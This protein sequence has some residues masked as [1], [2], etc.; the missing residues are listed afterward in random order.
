MT[1][2]IFANNVVAGLSVAALFNDQYITV[3]NGAAF[4]SPASGL[5][6]FN[7]TL[8][9]QGGGQLEIC[10]C[11]ARSGN[12]LTV[13]RGSDS[14]QSAGWPVGTTVSMRTTAA[15]LRD[16][17]DANYPITGGNLQGRMFLALDPTVQNEAATKNYVDLRTA[18]AYAT[19]SEIDSFTPPVDKAVS[20]DGLRS[21]TAGQLSALATATKTGLIPA[22]N[23]L[24][25]LV[26]GGLEGSVFWGVFSGATGIISWNPSSGQAGNTLPLAAP[27]N[28]GSYL[29][30]SVG[31]STPPGGAPAGTY[32][33]GDWLISDGATQWYHLVTGTTGTINAINVV[34]NPPVAGQ[35]NVQSAL[36]AIQA[37][38]MNY[39]PVTGGTMTATAKVTFTVSATKTT[40]L[41]GLDPTLSA[42]DHFVIA[43]GVY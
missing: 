23:E 36:T 8:Q 35:T 11:T 22:I 9:A 27:S 38:S 39:L 40:R 26:S 13:E 18:N 14:T 10:R 32:Y 29:I 24:K 28:M 31:G 15:N 42:I 33:P 19:H 16:F 7:V 30:C 21:I 17:Y 37:S 12:V 1:K 43:A 6:A 25:S 5:E 3:D 2:Y 4:P 34:V 41:D 20:A